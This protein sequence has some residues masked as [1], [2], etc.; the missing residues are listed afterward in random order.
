MADELATL[1]AVAQAKPVRRGELIGVHLVA[2]Y[3]CGNLFI[4]I[5]SQLGQAKS[6]ANR[7]PRVQA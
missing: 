6:W 7:R 3:G 4:R 2:T 1:D 5:A